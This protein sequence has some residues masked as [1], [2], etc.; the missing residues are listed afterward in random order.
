MTQYDS[1]GRFKIS[2][3]STGGP[4]SVTTI[5]GFS[6]TDYYEAAPGVAQGG[7]TFA[8]IW[9]GYFID[10]VDGAGQFLMGQTSGGLTGGWG[11]QVG[12]RVA[13]GGVT[14][15]GVFAVEAGPSFIDI[16]ESIDQSTVWHRAAPVH[17][18]MSYVSA[19]PGL[20]LW[21][22]GVRAR[23]SPNASVAAFLP[24]PTGQFR[25]GHGGLFGFEHAQ[26]QGFI[27]AGYLTSSLSASDVQEHLQACRDAGFG[28]AAG[29]LPWVHRWDASGGALA[30]L[31]DQVGT[32]S[33]TR[34]GTP[35]FRT[36]RI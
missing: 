1:N 14:P 9:Y 3:S 35:T 21:V 13:S 18:A 28:F 30:T 22:N 20:E 19:G 7:A 32:G 11:L 26:H 33:L 25:L 10:F 15:V 31:P 4:P 6:A 12:G 23:F 29:A 16:N 2:F 17:Y 8:A 24:S 36:R 27:G 34:V 5:E